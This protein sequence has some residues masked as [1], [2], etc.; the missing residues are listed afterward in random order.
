MLRDALDGRLQAL[1]LD[2][3]RGAAGRAQRG[4]DQEVGDGARNAQAPDA[5]AR[6]FPGRRGLLPG[7]EGAH[8]RRAAGHLHHGEA[9]AVRAD[10]SQGLELGESLVH[11]DDSGAAAGRVDDPVRQPPAELLGELESHR[12]LALDP[13]GLA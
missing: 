6:R 8:D 4:E 5:G 1:L 11:A 2:R 12:L 9:R 13:V 10:E 7:R 3:H